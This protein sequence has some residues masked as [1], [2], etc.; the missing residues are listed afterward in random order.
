VPSKVTSFIGFMQRAL[1][2]PW[3]T[4]SFDV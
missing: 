4:Q 1:Q 3:W 2:G